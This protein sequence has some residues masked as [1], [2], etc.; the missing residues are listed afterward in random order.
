MQG[1]KFYSIE[2]TVRA[3]LMRHLARQYS[4]AKE[5]RFG[6]EGRASMARG[7]NVLARAVAAT[8]GPKGRN[9]IIEQPFGGPKI[10]KGQSP[11][12][13]SPSCSRLTPP[14][15]WCNSRKVGHSQGQV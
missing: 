8:L 4:G 13:H 7:V 11:F 14:R 2:R 5:V 3:S 6:D 10:T 15:R 9:V 12:P 1:R